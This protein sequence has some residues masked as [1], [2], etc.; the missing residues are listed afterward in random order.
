[1]LQAAFRL[2]KHVGLVDSEVAKADRARYPEP[3]ADAPPQV[4]ICD[5]ISSDTWWSGARR[6]EAMDAYAKVMTNGEA[7]PCTTQQEDNATLTALMRGAEA[8]LLDFNR[9]AVLR[10]GADFDRQAPGETAVESLR[11][12]AGIYLPSIANAH[13]VGAKLAHAIVDDWVTWSA[14]PPK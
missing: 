4:S 1:M 9:V 2:T 12:P 14:A 13:R 7:N 5:T 8:N 10:A 6:A 3:A 11:P